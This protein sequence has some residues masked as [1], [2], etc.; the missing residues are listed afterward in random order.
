MNLEVS[1]S[2]A[3]AHQH[4]ALLE[5]PPLESS[6]NHCPSFDWR[7]GD[8]ST[9]VV[10]LRSHVGGWRPRCLQRW[11][12][13]LMRRTR[14][15]GRF[16]QGRAGR[17]KKKPGH[18][19]PFFRCGFLSGP[20]RSRNHPCEVCVAL[21]LAVSVRYVGQKKLNSEQTCD[22]ISPHLC[23]VNLDFSPLRSERSVG[24]EANPKC[25]RSL[26]RGHRASSTTGLDETQ[27][28]IEP[29]PLPPGEEGQNTCPG[30][31]ALVASLPKN[32]V[33]GQGGGRRKGG[34]V[35]MRK[36]IRV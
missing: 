2:P 14:F 16:S 4:S 28:V 8:S 6:L 10:S 11:T 23:L 21:Q 5:A 30:G 1:G 32:A 20:K 33:W 7:E 12:G 17:A 18:W 13:H 9:V 26:S 22:E 27:K 34:S 25:F 31:L 29:L 15:T 35:W 19:V 36:E 24:S 3:E